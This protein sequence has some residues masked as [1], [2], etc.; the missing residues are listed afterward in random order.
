M[1]NKFSEYAS[2]LKGRITLIFVVLAFVIELSIAFYW[3]YF[4][5]PHIESDIESNIKA[6]AQTQSNAIAKSFSD[7]DINKEKIISAIDDLFLLRDSVTGT[8]FVSGIELIMD[9][10]TLKDVPEGSLE[11]SRWQDVKT[12][13][14]SDD[15]YNVEIP[16][17]S[18]NTKELLGIARFHCSK[19]SFRHFEKSVKTSFII[20][21]CG[22]IILLFVSW[23]ILLY[24]LKPLQFLAESL[25][26][27]NIREIEPVTNRCRVVSSEI[28][29]VDKKLAELLGK[30]NDYTGELEALNRT[31]WASEEKYRQFLQNF[32]GIAYQADQDNL[33][34]MLIHGYVKDI[35][36]YEERE[37]LEKKL[38]LKD[39]IHP[40]DLKNV[41]DDIKKLKDGSE[42]VIDNEYRISRKD[43]KVRWVRDICRIVHPGNEKRI[44]IQGAFYDISESKNLE[45]R[46]VQ[47]QKMESIGT[48]AGG[49]AH[50]FNNIL[51]I[52]LGNAEL[53]K[54]TLSEGGQID[55]FIE[56]IKTACMRAKKMVQQILV[57]SRKS[58]QAF[59]PLCLNNVIR[60]SVNLIRATVPSTIS[61]SVNIPNSEDFIIGDTTQ[62][63]QVML[64]LCANSAHAMR[65]SG[66]KLDITVA[67][68]GKR[69]Q[70]KLHFFNLP[71]GEYLELSV[72]DTGHGIMPGIIERIF[73]PYFTTKGVGEGSGMGL[74][75]VHGIVT[76]HNGK[77]RV[78]SNPGK[79]TSIRI[80]FPV[81]NE[82]P[83][84]EK[85]SSENLFR[86]SERIL[87]IDDEKSIITM[88][89]YLFERLGYTV[90]SGTDPV[91]VYRLF[92]KE[93]HGF[94]LIITDMTM[95]KMTG[96]DLARNAKR[97]RPD[98]P[99]ILCTGYSDLVDE[100]SALEAGIEKYIMKPLAIY[101]VA[102]TVRKV[103]DSRAT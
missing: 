65:E 10:D 67:R 40:Q 58:E 86:G 45:S 95:P 32:V 73:D 24:L 56:E 3:L 8:P 37:I 103:L 102:E 98:I 49:I 33:E 85:E 51:G 4:M 16:L 27:G 43:G 78:E 74:A 92:E 59:T 101:N 63:S 75:V 39:L 66:G 5:M 52:I 97:I 35:S 17:F 89:T 50:D 15:Y 60:E 70:K 11:I 7:G 34:F 91:E 22:T 21:T 82:Q 68:F 77:I 69:D 57:F 46:L 83:A 96:F 36:G 29:L 6:L 93:P 18:V 26:G 31:L 1:S 42:Q 30:V 71:D 13:N 12:E 99:I 64:N 72:T 25:A 62:I 19:Y 54:L 80:A 41:L 88:L 2:S 28:R 100:E 47:A 81:V 9:Y 87:I 84:E 94:D 53:T 76:A 23:M 14:E 90:T 48:L 55:E 61:I 44:F 38:T 79:G 20:A